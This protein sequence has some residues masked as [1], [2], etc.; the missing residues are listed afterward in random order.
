MG[1]YGSKRFK[2]ELESLRRNDPTLTVLDYES[3]GLGDEGA[4]ALA[5]A[6]R[7]NETLRRLRLGQSGLSA[8]GLQRICR[9]L[10]DTSIAPCHLRRLD[11]SSGTSVGNAVGD[12]GAKCLAAL[13]TR[14]P[15]LR[16][17][18][19]GG[20]GIGDEGA[21]SIAQ[22]L[23]RN[24]TLKTLD[25]SNN[26]IS[27]IGAEELGTALTTNST[28]R[29]LSLWKNRVFHSG[30]EGLANG[31]VT[32]TTL[33]WLG[34]GCNYIGDEGVRAVSIA[35][36]S[37]ARDSGLLWL[38]LGGNLITDRGADHIGVALRAQR[39]NERR[40]RTSR[41]TSSQI[42]EPDD[43][44][45]DTDAPFEDV[46]SET[47][48]KER[49]RGGGLRPILE[50]GVTPSHIS[51][52][53][54]GGGE[55]V[56]GVDGGDEDE[57]GEEEGEGEKLEEEG[58]EKE[59]EEEGEG[60]FCL[61]LESLG[62]GG[63]KIGDI[64]AQH[65][66][67][68]L[69]SNTRLLSLG[70]ADNCVGDEGAS[71]L[72]DLLRQTGYLQQ[73]LLSGNEVA[74]EGGSKL[75]AALTQNTSLKALYLARNPL[76]DEVGRRC[77]E[78][79]G[80]HNNT[81]ETLDIHDTLMTTPTINKLVET[82]RTEGVLRLLGSQP[83]PVGVVSET[84]PHLPPSGNVLE[85]EN[86]RPKIQDPI[87]RTKTKGLAVSTAPSNRQTTLEAL[88]SLPPPSETAQSL[89]MRAGL[90][91]GGGA[92]REGTL[93]RSRKWSRR[94]SVTGFLKRK[95]SLSRGRPQVRDSYVRG[96]EAERHR[97]SWRPGSADREREGGTGGV[98]RGAGRGGEGAWQL[99]TTGGGFTAGR[100]RSQ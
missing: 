76:G 48:L 17:L 35:L 57:E 24:R 40:H 91:G 12:N 34:L 85:M 15:S 59:K 77:L 66:A 56:E 82:M 73:L 27:D 43:P 2:A 54:E 70:L 42:R 97:A 90:G 60:M 5:E 7:G 21:S 75:V 67:S 52:L 81:L 33:T 92:S 13:L 41:L 62:L 74:D 95:L 16:H 26:S 71:S 28:L 14:A 98:W 18:T 78:V 49:I 25:L 53:L 93:S 9:A 65:L 80:R 96:E 4:R 47:S 20:C 51:M 61:P 29:G 45:D 44:F 23:A 50:L 83:L 100:R 55:D 19:A 94:S 32:N 86:W 72:A 31:L 1:A 87:L 84:E 58:K 3:A 11:L 39:H 8:L 64:G 36:I 88:G 6:L 99:G 37:N 46:E 68:A 10:C 89:V 30:A 79:I 38:A 63:N 22:A 69:A